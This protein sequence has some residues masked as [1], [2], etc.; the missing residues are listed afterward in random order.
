MENNAMFN[1]LCE[2]KGCQFISYVSIKEHKMNKRNNPLYGRVRKI[3]ASNC[4]FNYN[5]E[6]AVNNRLE[7]A[8]KEGNFE[9][10]TLPWGKWIEGQE[11]KLIE[12][13]G[14]IYVRLYK[15]KNCKRKVEYLV[16]GRI[17]TEE[18]K[19]IISAYTPKSSG[20]VKQAEYGLSENQVEPFS[21]KLKDIVR[22]AI[23]DVRYIAFGSDAI[24]QKAGVI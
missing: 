9:S 7:K 8:G 14:E 23:N 16:D 11:N 20:S 18:E 10:S 5:Y 2:T 13:K 17:A 24:L 4:Q 15:A 21:V 6:K 12:H 1:A 19:A 22:L 3:T